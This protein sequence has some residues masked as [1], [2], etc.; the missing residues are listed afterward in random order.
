ML[1]LKNIRKTFGTRRVLDKVSFSLGAGQKVALVG[2]NGVGKSTLLRIVAGEE[3]FEK[4]ERQ[5]SKRA[6]IGYL[7]Q[8]SIAQSEETLLAYLRRM[9]GLEEIE[10]G[11]KILEPRLEKPEALEKY[12]ALETEYRRLG[13]Y[14]F[15]RKVRGMLEGLFLSHVGL[16]VLVA[17]LSGGEKRKAALAAVLLR[18]VDLLLLDEPTNNL[19]LPALL[20][21]ERYLSRSSATCLIASHDRRFL[22]NVVDKVIEIDWYR[23]DVTMYTGGWSDFA[24]MKAHAIRQH[25]EAYR[26]QEEER[27]RLL[28]S[29]EQKREWVERTKES[30][31]PDRDKLT[32]N[33]KKERAAKKFSTSAKVLEDREKR[34]R[35]VERPLERTPISIVLDPKKSEEE[36]MIV[37][38]DVIF[39]YEE[40]FR[41]EPVMLKVPFGTRLGILGTNGAG[42]ST[43]LKTL[44][45]EIAPLGGEMIRGSALVFGNLLQEHE[46]I[47]QKETLSGLFKKRLDMYDKDEVLM[48]LTRFQFSPDVIDDKIETLSPGERVRFILALLSAKGANVLVLDEPTNHLDLEAI[49]ALE[50]ALENYPGTLL[51]VTHDRRFLERVRLDRLLLL[52]NGV[53]TSVESYEAYA[54]KLLPQTERVLK[55]LEERYPG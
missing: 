23:R 39:G 5:V 14:D 51:L 32:S 30:I 10:R 48:H 13:G 27:S 43:L 49:E 3:S 26:M 6:L 31:A 52:E 44:S 28:S 47:P 35:G 12:E 38:K 19:D 2:Q 54:A 17:T 45:G 15:E 8:E 29:M 22:D 24:E 53:L 25:K 50:E 16:D 34:L 36:N 37:C 7:S 33:Y 42:K 40:G 46:D 9:A 1:T 21:L 55:R 41:S 4:G 11:M 18:G 20:W